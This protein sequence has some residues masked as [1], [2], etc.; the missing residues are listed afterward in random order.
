MM[1]LASEIVL[2]HLILDRLLNIGNCC[3]PISTRTDDV[4]PGES[5]GEQPAQ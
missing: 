2:P 1:G 3:A 4:L 5:T